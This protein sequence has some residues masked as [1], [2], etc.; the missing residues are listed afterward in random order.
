MRLYRFGQQYALW[1][2]IAVVCAAGCGRGDRLKT[3]PTTGTITFS[4][5]R[6]FPGN[7]SA[8]IVLE[9]IEHGLTATGSIDSDGRFTLRTYDPGDGA[10]AGRH[11]VSITPPMPAG[12]PDLVRAAPLIHPKFRNLETS[13]LEVTVEAINSNDVPITVEP[14]TGLGGPG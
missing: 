5:G 1:A 8:F 7:D 14:F 13:G 12:D 9:S 3:Y 4:D 2:I 11:R 10:V 6:R